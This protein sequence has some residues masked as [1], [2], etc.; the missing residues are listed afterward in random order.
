MIGKIGRKKEEH[1]LVMYLEEN[2]KLIK[3][4]V[5]TEENHRRVAINRDRLVASAVRCKATVVVIGHNHPNGS[6]YPSEK[7][8]ESTNRIVQALGMVGIRLADHMI[9]S[10][11]AY[12]SM[13]QEGQIIDPVNLNGSI[14]QFAQGLVRR[15]NDVNRLKNLL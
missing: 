14:H 4:D 12:Y 8:I 5:I 6:L 7:D 3:T 10:D 11:R 13:R 2:G 15:E 1:F 9:L